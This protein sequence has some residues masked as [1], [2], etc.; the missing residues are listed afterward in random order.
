MLTCPSIIMK[1]EAPCRLAS[2]SR[3]LQ[4]EANQ[5]VLLPESSI[6]QNIYPLLQVPQQAADHL[7]RLPGYPMLEK[8]ISMLTQPLELRKLAAW[9]ALGHGILL[10]PV[11]LTLLLL[12]LPVYLPSSCDDAMITNNCQIGDGFTLTSSKGP[13]NIVAGVFSCAAGNTAGLFAVRII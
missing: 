4:M 12:L 1:S 6:S 3:P 2:L 10:V 5:A 13:C 11:Q 9:L 7:L 8:G